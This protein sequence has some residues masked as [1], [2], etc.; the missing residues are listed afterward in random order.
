M[1]KPQIGG[2]LL[3]LGLLGLLGLLQLA[4]LPAAAQ[5][6]PSDSGPN[7][8]YLRATMRQFERLSPPPVEEVGRAERIVPDMPIT[9]VPGGSV[10]VGLPVVVSSP[11]GAAEAAPRRRSARP[12][13]RPGAQRRPV[14]PA[15]STARRPRGREAELAREL[16]DRDRQIQELRRR[17]DDRQRESRGTGSSLLGINP[18]GAAT[19]T[20]R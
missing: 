10:D 6:W 3:G 15:N 7:G 16:A 8:D 4:A 20:P 2:G 14:R 5:S 13:A 1:L 11:L 19:V 12:G 9:D 18:A 17:L